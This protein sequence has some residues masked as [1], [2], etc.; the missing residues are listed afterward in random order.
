MLIALFALIINA[1][2]AYKDII[3][4]PH[5]IVLNAFQIV[6]LVIVPTA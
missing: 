4:I 5:L 1:L 2:S 3:L 6:K